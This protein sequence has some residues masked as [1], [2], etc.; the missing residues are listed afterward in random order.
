VRD[1]GSRVRTVAVGEVREL[2]RILAEVVDL[3]LVWDGRL[4]DR[5]GRS[6][7]AGAVDVAVDQGCDIGSL[8]RRLGR[9]VL[10]RGLVRR[11][12]PEL[13]T[14]VIACVLPLLC[15]PAGACVQV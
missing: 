10:G 12:A 15:C 5:C 14:V 8:R 1:R 6:L 11:V 2:E 7:G 13:D 4:L 3:D 9:E